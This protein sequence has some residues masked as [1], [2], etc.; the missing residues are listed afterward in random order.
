MGT[1]VKKAK[2][3]TIKEIRK[4]MKA[5]KKKGVDIVA[6]QWGTE[7]D[8][9]LGYFVPENEEQPEVCALGALLIYKNG[10]LKYKPSQGNRHFSENDTDDVAAY[11]LGVDTD[12]VNAFTE[13]FDGRACTQ[14]NLD[15]D[16][17]KIYDT[18]TADWESGD[19][20]ILT[21]RHE[22]EMSAKDRELLNAYRM[23]IKL[24]KE[25]VK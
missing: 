21:K 10:D 6:G 7:F 18:S 13:G 24:A 8:D 12:W 17:G 9:Q 14:L 11:V 25:F 23:G 15:V 22:K 5:V 1:K 2:P 4:A 20:Q 19:G 3:G 16:G